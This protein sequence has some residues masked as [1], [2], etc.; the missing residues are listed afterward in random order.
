MA[1]FAAWLK[2]QESRQDRIGRAA[3]YW[4]KVTPGR[5]SS[6]QGVKRFVENQLRDLGDSADPDDVAAI[7]D[8][9]AGLEEAHVAY[10]KHEAHEQAIA[11][12]V[13]ELVPKTSDTDKYVQAG[14]PGSN[15]YTGWPEER[16]NRLE[17]KLDRVIRLLDAI[18][19]GQLETLFRES[20]R[21]HSEQGEQ[22]GITMWL[23]PDGTFDFEVLF[24][25]ADLAA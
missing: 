2:D 25:M 4:A 23:K 7:R 9:I 1:T 22:T 15:K 6:V 14:Q 10:A 12:G 20:F 8:A 18:S 5:L 3:C 13:T 24:R 21:T 16:L 19:S 11:A 17:D